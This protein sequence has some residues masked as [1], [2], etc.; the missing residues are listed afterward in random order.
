MKK[1]WNRQFALAAAV[2]GTLNWTSPP[3]IT[4]LN[5]VRGQKPVLFFAVISMVALLPLLYLYYQS[6]PQPITVKA[7]IEALQLTENIEGAKPDSLVIRFNYDFSNLSAEQQRPQGVPSVARIDLVGEEIKQGIRL[8]PAKAGRWVWSDDREIIFTPESDWPASTDY[9]VEFDAAIFAPESKLTKKSY[10]FTTPQFSAVIATVNFYQDPQ[11][12]SIRRVISTLQF[13]HPVDKKSLAEKLTMT[14]RPSGSDLNTPGKEYSY[15]ISYDKNLREA[16]LQSQAI[17]LPT[18]NNYMK[19]AIDAGLKTV[20]GGRASKESV[21][22]KILIPDIYSFLKVDSAQTQI[23]K[24]ARDEPEQLLRLEFSDDIEQ[25]ELFDKLEIYLLPRDENW[26]S[27]RQVNSKVLAKSSKINIKMVANEKNAAQAYSFIMDTPENSYLYLKIAPGLRSVNGFIQH[28]FYDTLLYSPRYPQEVK[29]A[30]EGS[31]LTYSGEHKLAIVSRAVNALKYTVG[32]VREEQLYHLITQ[33]RG[34]IN[35]PEFSSW[36][37]NQYNISEFESE[38]VDLAVEHPKKANYSSVDLTPFLAQQKQR[39]GLFF[40]NVQGWDKKNNRPIYNSEDKRLILITDLGIIVK[41]NADQSHDLFVQSIKT[42]EPVAGATIEL[43]GRNGI[44][45]YSQTTSTDGHVHLPSTQDFSNEKQPAVYV[46]KTAQDISFIPFARN[47]RQLNFSKFDIGGVQPVAGEE[48]ALNSYLFSDRGIYRPGEKVNIGAIV[49]NFDFTNVQD[50]PLEVVVYGPRNNEIKV[51]KISLAKF[52]FFD[53]Q[54]QTQPSS[55]TGRYRLS[56]HL[57]R[58][59]DRGREIGSVDFKVEEF[60]PDTLKIETTLLEIKSKGWTD[61]SSIKAQVVLQNLFGSPAQGRNLQGQLIIQP[62]RFVFDEYKEYNFSDPFFD[63]TQKPLTLNKNLPAQKTDSDGLASFDLDLQQFT[64]GAYRLQFIAEGFEQGG[65]RSVVSSNSVLISPLSELIGYKADGK[66]DYINA[67][68]SRN[69]EFI[70]INKTLEQIAKGQL[71]LKRLQIQHISTLV[72]QHDGTYKYQTVKKET[73]LD[74]LPIE[75]SAQGYLFAIDT[76][77]PGERALEISDAQN[78]RLARVEYSVVGQGN[79]TGQLDKNAELQLKLNKS[80]YKP[81]ELI[82]MNIKAPYTGAGLIT[83]ETDKVNHFQWFKTDSQSSMQRIRL[84]EGLQGTGYINVTFVR[85]VTSKEIFT[86]PLSYAVQPFSIDKSQHKIAVS[87]AVKKIV[88]PGQAMQIEYSSAQAAKIALFAV[89]QGILQVAQ[90]QT[91]DPLNHFLKKRALAVETAQILDLILPDFTILKT[92]SASGG[93]SDVQKLLAKNL[94]PFARKTDKPAVFWSGIYDANPQTQVVEFDVPET[95]AGSLTVIA[96]AVNESGV[97]VAQESTLVQGPFVISPNLLNQ[98]A[99]GD[100]FMVTVGVANM[101]KGSGKNAPVAISV[102][103]SDHLQIIDP[104]VT[105]INI[106]EGS[107]AKFSF[108]VKANNKLGA[109]LLR[110]TV[111]H[112][113]EQ[114]SRSTSLSIRPAMP[115]YSSFSSGF[116]DSGAVELELPIKRYADLAT[117][118]IAASASPL[119]L[120]DGLSAYL[121]NYPHGCTEQVVSQVFPLVGLMTHPAYAHLKN[122]DTYFAHAID[123][124]RERQRADGSFAFWPGQQSS[125]EYPSIYVMH[126]LIEAQSWGYPLPADMLQSGLNYLHYYASRPALTLDEAR[127]RANAIY[128]LTRTGV[129]TSNY[130]VDLEESL[131]KNHAKT[132]RKSILASYMAATYKLLQKDLVAE[133]LIREY[134]LDSTDAER[135]GFIDNDDFHSPLSQDA[136]YIYLLAKHFPSHA[137]ELSGKQLSKLTTPIFKGQYNTISAAYSILALGAQSQLTLA[138]DQAA[139]IVFSAWLNGQKKTVLEAQLKPFLTADYAP[140]SDQLSI[141]SKHATPLYFL[142]IESGFAQQLPTAPIREGLEIERDFIDQQGNKIR[143]FEQGKEITVRLKVRALDNKKLTHI[144]VIDL[145]PGGFEV[146]RSSLSRNASHWQ[147]DYIDS[148]EDRVIYYGDF[149][150]RVRELTYQVKLTAQ[151][152]FVVP[153][154]YAESMYDRSIRAVSLPDTF[155]VTAAKNN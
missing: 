128:L 39:L 135:S 41:N 13:S 18:E 53:F 125:A 140:D 144:A 32:R 141:Q 23:I 47:A 126:F 88:R 87:L 115:Y 142:N 14:M 46:V 112:K 86:S 122:G 90:Y 121:K 34:D 113:E 107:E 54:Y 108:K 129:V 155:S 59:K 79:L 92:L 22:E 24:N 154:S 5:K 97:G 66:L 28:A 98:A 45:L 153:P 148:R 56:L 48:N 44:A 94:N 83:I 89:D 26:S 31:L 101:I 78:R 118:S 15:E 100:Q 145:L 74:T 117:Q 151:G 91:P 119:V 138:N 149:D 134:Q 49:K 3:W 17:T 95:F 21:S 67:N 25:Q 131:T 61:K 69:I 85:D 93:G 77:D 1:L 99:P 50:I 62:A 76:R 52:G 70:A 9:K 82:E 110:F 81:G 109:A 116:T 65:G 30:G 10:S 55:D 103:A 63:T 11:D 37:F 2:F 96:V 72:K 33:T 51:Q 127:N 132:W 19:V 64:Q 150:N 143:S 105:Q 106:D 123:K 16:Y 40:I 12:K 38:I 27:P 147:A 120:V 36:E 42:G 152:E 75:I 114:L 124:L 29:I 84:P 35:N 139:E 137:K 58:G 104:P 60:Q 57:M 111:S 6:L 4:S 8:S 7:E 68:S 73:E 43:L 130:L 102:S 80:D 71:T 136:Q 133:N 20:F 146:I